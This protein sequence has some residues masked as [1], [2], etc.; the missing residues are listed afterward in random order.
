MSNVAIFCA[1][2]KLCTVGIGDIL[3]CKA[4]KGSKLAPGLWIGRMKEVRRH[5][6]ML[7]VDKGGALP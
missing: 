4:L 6:V 1:Y 7:L 5:K 3:V 2:K